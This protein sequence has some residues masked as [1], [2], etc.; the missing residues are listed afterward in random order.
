MIAYFVEGGLGKHVM[1]SGLIKDLA[2]NDGSKVVIMSAYPEI[3]KM[4][5]NVIHS[6]SFSQPEAYEKI[7]KKCVD[8][9]HFE[10]YFSSFMKGKTHLIKNW[11][12]GFK[13]I[14][15]KNKNVPQIVIGNETQKQADKVINQI[16]SDYILVQLTGG[17]P[18]VGFNENQNSNYAQKGQIRNYPPE[19]S[20]KLIDMI[21]K[22]FPKLRIINCTLPNEGQLVGADRIKLSYML[23]LSLL[24]RA[25]TF[26]GID[27]FLQQFSAER[28]TKKKGVVLWGAT[29]PHHFGYDHNYNLSASCVFGVPH[30]MR[31][32]VRPI[33]DVTA[34]NGVPFNCAQPSC[35]NIKPERVFEKFCKLMNN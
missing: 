18:C 29:G 7:L 33:G 4:H 25:K 5:P 11:C 1:F 32:Y 20:Q 19:L 24:R 3:F 16:K 27:S 10:P 12:R 22:G 34:N 28:S 30:C 9:R 13:I 31:P 8:M 2:K 23:Y 35:I 15:D 21:K 26:I 14:Y 6:L 17:Q